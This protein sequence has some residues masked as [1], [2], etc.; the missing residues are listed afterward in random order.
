MLDVTFDMALKFELAHRHPTEDC[1]RL[2]FRTQEDLLQRLNP[3]WADDL[4]RKHEDI[5]RRH[6]FRDAAG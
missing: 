4:R 6:P 5:L 3:A 2:L 1:R